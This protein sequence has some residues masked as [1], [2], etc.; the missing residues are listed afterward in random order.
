MYARRKISVL[1]GISTIVCVLYK[2]HNI[3]I[4]IFTVEIVKNIYT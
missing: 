3:I 1:G 2:I 4:F